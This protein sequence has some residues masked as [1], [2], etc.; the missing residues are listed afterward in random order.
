MPDTPLHL[1]PEELDLYL[2][3]RLPTHRTS[4][5]ETCDRCRLAAEETRELVD[6]LAQLPP[7]APGALFADRIVASLKP[8]PAAAH[9]LPEDL[10]LWVEG[11][12]PAPREAHLRSCPECQQL[13]NAERLLVLQLERLP[14]FDP[15]PGLAVRVL[16]R[17]DLPV[18]SVAGAWRLWRSRFERNPV[19][20][21]IAA[22]VAVLLGGSMAASAAW[23]AGNQ[24]LITGLGGWVVLRGELWFWQGVGSLQ[25]QP[26]FEPVRSALTP[27]RAA[28]V[29]AA[30]TAMYT[31]GVLTL[32]R[33]LALPDRQV[34]R[35][36][37]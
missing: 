20:V 26:W 7:V 16:D 10:D 1:D 18:T 33:L 31:A 34:A 12:L 29:L 3:G 17:V 11:A 8:S 13:A 5:L 30:V 2:D 9:L 23:A 4:H 14:L 6:A 35:A 21:G 15:A 24:D 32:R 22:S 27:G 36:A 37:P 28:V 25:A 19:A